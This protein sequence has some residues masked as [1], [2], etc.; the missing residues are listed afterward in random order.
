MAR[1]PAAV[2]ET[3]RFHTIV[4]R[5][6]VLGCDS[7]IANREH[8]RVALTRIEFQIILVLV[9]PAPHTP[10]CFATSFPCVCFAL[11]TFPLHVS[12]AICLLV[13]L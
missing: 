2:A 13:Q 1:I 3:V 8:D 7:S 4:E 12:S 5:V 11:F 10:H 9:P 6:V